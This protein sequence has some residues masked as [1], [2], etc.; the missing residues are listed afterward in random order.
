MSIAFKRLKSSLPPFLVFAAFFFSA[1]SLASAQQNAGSEDP[2]KEASASQAQA[3]MAS[4]FGRGAKMTEIPRIKGT[5]AL[6][7][8]DSSG[9]TIDDGM[10]RTVQSGKRSS[11]NGER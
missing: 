10:L 2:G 7:A 3:T 4:L 8:F 6:P 11:G 1:L 5:I 9:I